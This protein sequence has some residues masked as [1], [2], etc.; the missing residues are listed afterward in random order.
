MPDINIICFVQIVSNSN[1]I[2][3]RPTEIVPSGGPHFSL[4][5]KQIKKL[6]RH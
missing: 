3:K 2:F 1:S 4:K 5:S 6:T